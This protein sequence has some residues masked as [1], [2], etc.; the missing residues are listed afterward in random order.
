MKRSLSLCYF[1]VFVIPPCSLLIISLLFIISSKTTKTKKTN[2]LLIFDNKTQENRGSCSGSLPSVPQGTCFNDYPLSHLLSQFIFQGTIPSAS[3]Y[4]QDFPI[5]TRKSFLDLYT[6][7][8]S[9]SRQPVLPNNPKSQWLYTIIVHF[10][11]ISEYSVGGYGG[12]SLCHAVIQAPRLISSRGSALLCS[13]P[14]SAVWVRIKCSLVLARFPDLLLSKT[15]K[16][17]SI[18]I[19]I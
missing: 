12:V 18:Y 7:H 19:K 5:F 2:I 4:G 14:S 16:T 3:K 10:L 17:N 6:L 13:L 8:F 15:P 11:L 9:W 1:H